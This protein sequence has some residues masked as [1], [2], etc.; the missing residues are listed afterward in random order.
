[1]AAQA[2]DP[3][4]GLCSAWSRILAAGRRVLPGVREERGEVQG[5]GRGGSRERAGGCGRAGGIVE[6]LG[7]HVRGV[8]F[9]SSGQELTTAGTYAG[10][11]SRTSEQV[12]PRLAVLAVRGAGRTVGTLR[13]GSGTSTAGSRSGSGRCGRSP[14]PGPPRAG[15]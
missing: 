11:V 4:P 3:R 15:E 10:M 6:R 2:W 5:P 13:P 7:G 1:A 9:R 8:V 12:L 14:P